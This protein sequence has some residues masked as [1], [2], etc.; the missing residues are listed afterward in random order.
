[1]ERATGFRWQRIS[2]LCEC[3][4]VFVIAGSQFIVGHCVYV[5]K[6]SETS[7]YLFKL[8]TVNRSWSQSN[9]D[10]NIGISR[11]E[12]SATLI[13]DK[14]F[15]YSV[16]SRASCFGPEFWGQ[17][18]CLDLIQSEA[19]HFSTNTPGP[20]FVWSA[21]S[22]H[23][24]ELIHQI[25]YLGSIF[26]N[27]TEAVIPGIPDVVTVAF[28]LCPSKKRWTR[29]A[30]KGKLPVLVRKA[31]T[32]LIKDHLFVF[33][34]C[35]NAEKP[36]VYGSRLFVLR[37]D[38]IP[39]Q[40]ETINPAGAS[41]TCRSRPCLFS[42]RNNRL[43]LLGDSTDRSVKEKQVFILERTLS[44]SS[45]WVEAA[46]DRGEMGLKGTAP[47]NW[48]EPMLVGNKILLL[49]MNKGDEYFE[50]LPCAD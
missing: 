49:G 40:W 47:S 10:G 4:E 3:E 41:P 36:T 33:E 31:G 1:M 17:L 30:M 6:R 12:F 11:Y 21:H 23:Y 16:N 15:L 8:D 9:L 48:G 7:M 32:C 44:T 34:N 46:K 28:T 5:L 20:E 42:L 29:I 43:F 14:V 19:K 22:A 38:T 13:D 45:K 24:C 37:L 50:L 18:Y 2:A 26:D 39:Y 25:I 27:T 35:K